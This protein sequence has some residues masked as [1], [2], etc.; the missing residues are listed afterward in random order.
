MNQRLGF[1]GRTAG[2]YTPP[3]TD[4]VTWNERTSL[5]FN[6]AFLDAGADLYVAYVLPSSLIGSLA[7]K[8]LPLGMLA[9]DLRAELTMNDAGSALFTA[10]ESNWPTDVNE[11]YIDSLNFTSSSSTFGPPFD[12]AILKTAF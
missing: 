3:G 11:I 5:A 9:V 8:L 4:D 7:S 12:S 6:G 2:V 10:D 1:F